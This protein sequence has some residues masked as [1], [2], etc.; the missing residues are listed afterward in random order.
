MSLRGLRRDVRRL[1]ELGEVIATL[2]SATRPREI[3][4]VEQSPGV[5]VPKKD[6]REQRAVRQVIARAQEDARAIG[7]D[8]QTLGELW[9][10]F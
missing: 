2:S 8:L 7:E 1:R 10:K 9:R 4:M 6:T 5:Y 3:Q